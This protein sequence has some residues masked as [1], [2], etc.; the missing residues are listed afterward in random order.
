MTEQAIFKSPR[1]IEEDERQ[2]KYRRFESYMQMSDQGK[3]TRALALAAFSDECDYLTER[4]DEV[5]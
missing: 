3:L 4:E 5:A 1:A 2:Y